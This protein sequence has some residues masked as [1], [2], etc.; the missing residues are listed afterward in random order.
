MLR[1]ACCFTEINNLPGERLFAAKPDNRLQPATNTLKTII[2]QIHIHNDATK[3][4]AY[5]I[6]YV[7]TWG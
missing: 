2:F 1:K 5:R 6:Y 4:I 3:K 7:V